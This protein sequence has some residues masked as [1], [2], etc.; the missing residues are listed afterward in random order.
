MRR[1]SPLTLI[2]TVTWVSKRF[3]VQVVSTKMLCELPIQSA[4]SLVSVRG[5]LE[6]AA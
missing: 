6:P 4:R 3:G 2:L 1:L 5:V